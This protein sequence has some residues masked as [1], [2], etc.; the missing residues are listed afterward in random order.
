[1]SRQ[2]G[3]ARGVP[4]R[5]GSGLRW[6]AVSSETLRPGSAIGLLVLL[7]GLST[8]SVLSMRPPPALDD[9]PATEFA[10]RRAIEHVRAMTRGPHPTGTAAHG[11]VRESLVAQLERLGLE[12]Q[13]QDTLGGTQ[14][15]GWHR[16]ARL[17]NV[18]ARLAGT[19]PSPRPAVLLSAHYDSAPGSRGASD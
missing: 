12:V 18:V 3:L 10:A 5:L 4:R 16:A 15:F 17:R 14:F 11:R 2:S 7:A 9:A 13:V 6:P 8:L 1:F 19:G